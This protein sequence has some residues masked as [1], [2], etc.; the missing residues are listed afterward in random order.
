MRVLVIGG[1]R[2]IGRASVE[3]L[4]ARGHSVMVVHRGETE[5]ADLVQAEHLHTDR[6]N[7]AG[8][9]E[10]LASFRPDA[11]LDC[12]ALTRTDAQTAV[13]A[14]PRAAH[15]VVLSSIDVYQAYAALLNGTDQQP[16][17]LTEQS[18][19]R[20]ER[21]FNRGKGGRTPDDYEKLD[22]EDVYLERGATVLRLPMVHGAHDRQRRE[23]FILRRV[24]GKRERIP[25]GAGT[26]LTC[27]GYV[28]DIANG[29]CLALES[30]TVAGE[31]FNLAQAP[32]PS[33]RLWAEQILQV[34]GSSAELVRVPDDAVPDDMR[35]TASQS[36]HLL[37]DAAKARRVLGWSHGD[38]LEGL[39]QSVA[40]HLQNPPPEWD[41]DFHRDDEALG[42]IRGEN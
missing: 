19:V 29:I 28:G 22:V 12:T 33:M 20:A 35:L 41:A 27:R 14:L 40:W 23:E 24:R 42:E 9:Q 37:A 21:Y 13:E 39:R 7:L 18:P 4:V 5:P 31:V 34:A 16:V 17:P 36:Q 11:V 3:L 38:P 10:E 6:A 15:V 30:Q 8:V 1:T 32:T 26:W 25:I 2:F